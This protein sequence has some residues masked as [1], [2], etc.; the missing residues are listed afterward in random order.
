MWRLWKLLGVTLYRV[1][2]R[3]PSR[4]VKGK[5]VVGRSGPMFKSTAE[6]IAAYGNARWSGSHWV[7]RD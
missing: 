7:E 5:M 1:H 2:Y 6:Y 3:F 4:L